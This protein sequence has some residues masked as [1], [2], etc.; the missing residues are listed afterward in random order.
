MSADPPKQRE[1]IY[2]FCDETSFI[3]EDYMGVGGLALR[4]SRIPEVVKRL[5]E[6]RSARG[7]L[8]EIKWESTRDGNLAVRRD[9]VDYMVQLVTAGN[10]HLH[11]RFAPFA[12]YEHPGPRRIYDTVSKMYYPLLLHRALK[13]YGQTCRLFIRPDDGAC[14]IELEK[15][16]DAL[17]I[18]GFLRYKTASDCIHSIKC[19]NSRTEPLLQFVDVSLGALTAFRNSRHVRPG[20]REAKRLLAEHAY[21]VFGIQNLTKNQVSE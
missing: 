6:I 11:I 15:F 13:N 14:T 21:A 20:T 18:E 16:V 4:K 17:H 10:V 2:Y 7:A 9:Y 3:G 5:T 19:L 8:G 12:Q 1:D